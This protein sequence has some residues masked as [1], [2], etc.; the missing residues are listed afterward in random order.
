MKPK[1]ILFDIDDTLCNTAQTKDNVYSELYHTNKKFK[2]IGEEEFKS[3]LKRISKEYYS[4]MVDYGFNA[5]SRAFIWYKLTKELEIYLKVDEILKLADDYW[6]LALKGLDLYERVESTLPEL[7]KKGLLV[8]TATAGDYHSK[9]HK[10]KKLGIDKYF[11]Y[12]FTTELVQK[13][14]ATGEIFRYIMSYLELEPKEIIMVGD[15]VTEDILPANKLG[16]TTVQ[17][18]MRGDQEVGRVGDEK[19]DFVINNFGEILN[20]VK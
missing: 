2:K 4:E 6:E 1:A 9:T 19:A 3:V 18:M 20:I 8:A 17:A 10:L 7:N 13:P 5:Y 14:K 12:N 15:K 11:K 16:I